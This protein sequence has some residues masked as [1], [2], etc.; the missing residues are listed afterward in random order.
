MS[1]CYKPSACPH[2]PAHLFFRGFNTRDSTNYQ[3]STILPLLVS[4]LVNKPASELSSKSL[5]IIVNGQDGPRGPTCCFYSYSVSTQ[6]V[7]DDWNVQCENINR[8]LWLY[9]VARL[10]AQCELELNNN[11]YE[12]LEMDGLPGSNRPSLCVGRFTPPCRSF[13][14]DN[15]HLVGHYPLRVGYAVKNFWKKCR[16]SHDFVL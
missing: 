10:L 7:V 4:L 13:I 9:M 1:T 11:T 8:E 15:G 3:G 16:F 12:H 14:S 2:A 6:V 5:S